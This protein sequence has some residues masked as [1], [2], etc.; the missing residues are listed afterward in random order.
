MNRQGSRSAGLFLLA[1]LVSLPL[2]ASTLWQRATSAAHASLAR[3]LVAL[4]VALWII[5]VTRLVWVI[6]AARRGQRTSGGFGWIAGAILSVATV[7][8]TPLA[9]SAATASQNAIHHVAEHRSDVVQAGIGASL[10]LALAAKKRRDELAQLRIALD[11]QLVDGVIEEL[12]AGDEQ[13][14]QRVRDLVPDELDGVIDVDLREP[15]TRILGSDE[16]PLLVVP[17][18]GDTYQW[19]I[20]FARPGGWL[21]VDPGVPASTLESSATALHRDGLVKTG[22][23][24]LETTRLLAL[25]SSDRVLVLH[26]SAEPLDAELAALCIRVDRGNATTCQAPPKRPIPERVAR[27]TPG[28]I[29]VKLLR[30]DVVVVGTVTPFASDL[31]RRCVE[32][33]AYLALHRHEPVSGDRLRSRVLGGGYTD[34]SV[35]TLANTASAVRRSL[36]SVSGESRLLPVSPGGHYRTLDVTSDIEA[37]YAYVTEARLEDEREFEALVSALSLIEGEPLATELR[38]FEWFLAEGHLGRLQREAEWAAL[39]LARLATERELFDV[40]FWA[41][42]RGRLVDPY[43]DVLVGALARVPRHRPVTP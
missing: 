19:S 41:L 37:F 4:L 5:A 40:A 34:A 22:H 9:S 21:R 28:G 13:M 14:L 17:V 11:D 10:P 43:S 27:F 15:P 31:R 1:Y 18:P 29:I 20:A 32:M 6:I 25:R 33:T 12:R 24:E 3:G 36:G 39:R 30:S 35:R 26:D 42:E 7:I 16:A 23:S 2:V 8:A 38:G